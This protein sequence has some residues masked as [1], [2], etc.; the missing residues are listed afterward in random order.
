[1]KTPI[2]DFVQAYAKSEA[3][4]LHMPGH[5]GV[6]ILGDEALDITEISGADVL[7]NSKGIIKE[8]QNIASELFGTE[9]TFYSTEGSSLCI[10]AMLYLIKLFS[11]SK[12][13][14]PLILAARNVHKTFV[15]AAALMN[16]EVEWL[17]GTQKNLLSCD[18]DLIELEKKLKK[19]K[20]VAVYLTSP[21]Y[22][23]NMADIKE[24]ADLCHR[25]GTILAVDN[26]HGAYLKF[27]AKSHHPMDLGADICCDSA[28]KTLPVLTGGAYLHISKSA[29]KFFS[30]N[31]ETSLSI[32]ASTSPSYLV[33]QSLDR[34]NDLINQ[35]FKEK[36]SKLSA[37]LKSCA[38]E[39]K[40]VGYTIILNEPLKLTL[41]TKDY[42]YKGQELGAIL[43]KENIIP[44]FADPDF[45]VLMFSGA[46]DIADIERL[47]KVL[48]SIPR[49]EKITEMPPTLEIPKIKMS[50]NEAI[51]SL[52]E[53]IPTCRAEGK[54]LALPS[55][56]C[57]PA[58]PILVCGEEI[59][60][61]AIKCFEYYGIEEI[62]VVK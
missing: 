26:A 14:K 56:S 46:N 21:D 28:H 12:S 61:S 55:V 33:L 43:E 5:K 60:E 40:K 2:C 15:S 8:S 1:M 29:D 51:Y 34:A 22:L 58:V 36:L 6:N 7:Y 53:K 57:P 47:I 45:L 27:L 49:K 48:L 54:V 25:Y 13:K 9:K 16:I 35:G 59:N 23:G 30:Q 42:G 37:Q 20:P 24:I 50:P 17:F 44:E 52:G 39:L 4:R 10:R 3:V 11:K 18:I 62:S 19:K 41:F 31:A 38:D 32:F